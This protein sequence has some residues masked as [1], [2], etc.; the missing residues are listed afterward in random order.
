MT[1]ADLVKGCLAGEAEAIRL[2][3]ERFQ[4]DVYS[5]SLR[6]LRH[7][8]DAEDVCQEVFL[9]VFRSLQRWDSTR[10]LRP[11][12]LTIAVNRCRTWM[13]RRPRQPDLVEHLADFPGQGGE[14]TSDELTEAIQAGLEELRTDYREV[15]V[16]FH[17]QGL[18]V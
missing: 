2:L 3:V 8:Q 6:M 7:Q 4:S 16:L 12:I 17:Q 10:A 18:P 9:R 1:D 11:W 15:F 14:P 5:V 13:A